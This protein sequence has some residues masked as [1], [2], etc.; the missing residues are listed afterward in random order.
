MKSCITMLIHNKDDIEFV[1]EFPCLLGHPVPKYMAHIAKSVNDI[2][3]CKNPFS[4]NLNCTHKQAETQQLYAN[5]HISLNKL[6]FK[7][8][9]SLFALK[10][11]R[12]RMRFLK[13]RLLLL[14]S[15][16]LFFLSELFLHFNNSV[17]DI[18][19]FI[20]TH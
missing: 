1:T 17:W 14:E 16:K 8:L 9:L 18:R 10:Q 6:I 12:I 2:W 3:F 19:F 5:K 11:H 4:I 20:S 13:C 15:P 7:L